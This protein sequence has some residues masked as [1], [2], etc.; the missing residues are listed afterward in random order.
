MMHWG[1]YWP[2]R[3]KEAL[4]FPLPHQLRDTYEENV[5]HAVTAAVAIL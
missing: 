4:Q 5:G 3:S 1:L 2:Q